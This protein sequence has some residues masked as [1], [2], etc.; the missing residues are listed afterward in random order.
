[1]AGVRALL[2]SVGDLAWLMTPG[3]ARAGEFEL[4]TASD[5]VTNEDLI[6]RRFDWRG[7]AIGQFSVGAAATDDIQVI[8][9]TAPTLIDAAGLHLGTVTLLLNFLGQNLLK[10]YLHDL[11][12]LV[13]IAVTTLAGAPGVGVGFTDRGSSTP[14]DA[15]AAAGV[16]WSSGVPEWRFQN[17]FYQL[18]SSSTVPT[19]VLPGSNPRFDMT[20]AAIWLSVTYGA[21]KSGGARSYSP[22]VASTAVLDDAANT[23]AVGPTIVDV[24]E[25]GTPAIISQGATSTGWD[26]ALQVYE[27]GGAL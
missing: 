23:R 7:C 6:C 22:G 17:T 24:A 21:A 20:A 2:E 13:D 10:R 19:P 16:A 9:G 15:V 27:H 12:A 5:P 14:E 4:L 26:V 8:A 1:M 18:L 3:G 25:R 11:R